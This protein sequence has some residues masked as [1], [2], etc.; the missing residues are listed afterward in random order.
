MNDLTIGNEYT[1][2]SLDLPIDLDYDEWAHR[3]KMLLLLERA[4]AWWIGDWLLYGERTYGERYAQAVEATGKTPEAL[5][6][7]MWVAE[8]MTPDR[9]R[10]ALTF[11]H[12]DAVAALPPAEADAIL[13]EAEA[14]VAEGNPWP[15]SEVRRRARKAKGEPENVETKACECPSCGFDLTDWLANR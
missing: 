13:D 7:Y 8:R 11:G 15:V 4:T 5:R 1:P 14:A 9:R 10:E 6:K 12:H 2:V 3:G